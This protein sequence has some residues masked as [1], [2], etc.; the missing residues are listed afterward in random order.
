MHKKRRAVRLLNFAEM[1]GG[2]KKNT[3]KAKWGKGKKE[4]KKTQLLPLNRIVHIIH[5]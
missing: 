2:K 4:K 3:G 1:G 5:S